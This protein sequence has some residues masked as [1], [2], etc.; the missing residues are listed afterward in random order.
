MVYLPSHRY[1]KGKRSYLS[2]LFWAY[3][4]IFMM[5][6]LELCNDP[7]IDIMVQLIVELEDMCI[8]N[9]VFDGRNI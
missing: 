4:L 7:V 2:F 6:N 9:F 5:Q 1:V 8:I 3:H